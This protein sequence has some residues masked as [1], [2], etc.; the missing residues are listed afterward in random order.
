M[1]GDNRDIE[2]VVLVLLLR[3]SRDTSRGSLACV[4]GTIARCDCVDVLKKSSEFK[5]RCCDTVYTIDH[6]V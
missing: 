6:D 4:V 1:L 3:G 5:L 2:V